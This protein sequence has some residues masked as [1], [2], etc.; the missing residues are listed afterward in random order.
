MACLRL[1]AWPLCACL[2]ACLPCRALPDTPDLLV[3]LVWEGKAPTRLAEAFWVTWI[4]RQQAGE[5]RSDTWGASNSWRWP[6]LAGL[7]AAPLPCLAAG[8]L[9]RAVNISSWLMWKLGQPIS[10]LEVI[11]NGSHGLHAVGDEGVSVDSA[12]GKRRLY[13]RWGYRC[14]QASLGSFHSS[15]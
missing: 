12:D 11:R 3:D 13:I 8:C 9:L 6:L 7:S 2:P 15:I 1:P 4:P 10:P 14:T 5:W